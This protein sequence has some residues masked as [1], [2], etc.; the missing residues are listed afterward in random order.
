[1]CV[2]FVIQ[3]QP[4]CGT[5]LLRTAMHSR[6]D[7]VC[8]GEVF[9]PYSHEHGFPVE[10]PTVAEVLDHCQAQ[11]KVTGFVAHAFV[12][13]ESSETGLGLDQAYEDAPRFVPLG[14]CGERFRRTRQ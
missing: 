8:F 4:R 13:L 1:M 7:V 10:H 6:G 14:V 9:N 11:S 5:H 12:G 2:M 3:S